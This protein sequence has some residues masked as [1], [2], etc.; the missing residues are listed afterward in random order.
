MAVL[1]IDSREGGCGFRL[2]ASLLSFPTIIALQ[3]NR[4]SSELLRDSSGSWMQLRVWGAVVRHI[5]AV[6]GATVG[7]RQTSTSNTRVLRESRVRYDKLCVYASRNGQT[8]KKMS[9]PRSWLCGNLWGT[10]T[11]LLRPDRRWKPT[12]PPI[13]SNEIN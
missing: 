1:A 13:P 10:K 7:R 5:I 6:A 3:T 4:K 8:G 9:S 12:N 11:P 2:E